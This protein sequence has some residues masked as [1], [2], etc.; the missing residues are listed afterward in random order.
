MVW[1]VRQD[2]NITSANEITHLSVPTGCGKNRSGDVGQPNFTTSP[3]QKHC[4]LSRQFDPCA[5]GHSFV[6]G[7][8]SKSVLILSEIKRRSHYAFLE[9][10]VGFAAS[11]APILHK[12]KNALPLSFAY[13]TNASFLLYFEYQPKH[14]ELVK[15]STYLHQ[16]SAVSSH[17]FAHHSYSSRRVEAL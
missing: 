10:N 14:M 16:T 6:H 5:V 4:D 8:Y 12:W 9:S 17:L 1:E 15:M 11:V 2:T 3:S 13:N 7:P